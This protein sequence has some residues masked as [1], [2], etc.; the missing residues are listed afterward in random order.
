[1]PGYIPSKRVLEEGG[2]EPEFS[3]VYYAKPGPYWPEV[4]EI[5][6]G[7]VTEMLGESFAASDNQP[8]APFHHNRIPHSEPATFQRVAD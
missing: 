2:Y 7:A 8:H 4:E 6:I 3:Q 5:L 1:M